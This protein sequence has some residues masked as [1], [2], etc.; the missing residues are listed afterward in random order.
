MSGT[1][2][3]PVIDWDACWKPVFA[4]ERFTQRSRVAQGGWRAVMAGL[5]ETPPPFLGTPATHQDSYFFVPR[6][7][8]YFFVPSK[9]MA[10]Q[11]SSPIIVAILLMPNSERFRTN[12]V[13]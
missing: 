8:S 10:T 6:Q 3:P 2:I 13:E 4:G 12:C 9:P 7:D 11:M 5:G 1:G